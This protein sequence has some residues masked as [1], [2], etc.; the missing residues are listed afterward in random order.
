MK[1]NDRRA[2]GWTELEVSN[3]QESRINLLQGAKDLFG[4]EAVAAISSNRR[5]SSSLW[6]GMF[7]SRLEGTIKRHCGTTA[8]PVTEPLA[9]ADVG[10]SEIC[11][12]G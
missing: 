3:A 9:G 7:I 12:T 10:L 2:V 8:S 11:V 5:R 1:K 6:F 4:P